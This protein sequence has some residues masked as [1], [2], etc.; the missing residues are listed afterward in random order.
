MKTL[1]IEAV[2]AFVLTAD[3][4]SFTRAAEAMD[5]TQS[6]V[7]LKIKRL[8]DALGR[9][10]LERTPRHVRLSADGTAFLE[11]A[12]ELV[13][14]HHG[15]VG[16]FSSAQQRLVIGVSHHV[17]GADL[18]ML[19][20]RMNDA[21]P[22]LVLEIRVATSRDVLDAFD[23]GL[24]DA[25]VVLHHDSRRLDGET[26]LSESFGW[27]AAADFEYRPPQPLRLA[28][29]AAPCSVRHMAVSALDEAGVP[30]TEVFVGG[31]VATIGAAVS[32]GLAVAALGHRVAPSGT[33]DVGTQYGLPPLPTRDVVLHANQTDARARQALRTLGAALR[34]SVGAR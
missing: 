5:T 2:H 23:R 24:L 11:P 17:V 33:V 15:A 10:L 9:R 14:A 8:E 16:A 18:P 12:R 13:A 22:G 27:M 21:E 29:Q 31:G 28:T 34:S 19:L 6:A 3:L 20:R 30:W 7:S 25:A 32:A 1:D 26:I 4:K